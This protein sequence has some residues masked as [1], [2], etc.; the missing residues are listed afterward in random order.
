MKED[1]KVIIVGPKKVG[2]TKGIFIARASK[3]KLILQCR[4]YYSSKFKKIDLEL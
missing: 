4:N 3:T 2:E 1:G